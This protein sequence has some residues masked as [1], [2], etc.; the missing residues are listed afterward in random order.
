MRDEAR[1]QSTLQSLRGEEAM[2]P[3]P[4]PPPASGL[5]EPSDIACLFGG[6]RRILPRRPG[7]QTPRITSL[8]RG[9]RTDG[10]FEVLGIA[11]AGLA[12]SA[13][14]PLPE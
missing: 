3:Q 11:A 6:D 7:A 10:V 5:I 4:S 2:S 14:F 9:T 8:W 12:I 1:A 13:R